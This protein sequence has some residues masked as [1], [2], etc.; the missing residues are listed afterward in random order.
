[1]ASRIV[2]PASTRN[3]AHRMNGFNLEQRLQQIEDRVSIKSVVD[4]FSTLADQK[5]VASQLS[6][7]TEDA[8]VETYFEAPEWNFP[9]SLG[10]S[11]E[12]LMTIPAAECAER[13]I[14]QMRWATSV[15]LTPAIGERA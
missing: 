14:A 6:L 8:T 5:D 7:F 10:V 9:Q 1:M 3:Q 12:P 15:S 2:S 13:R 11:G 4:T